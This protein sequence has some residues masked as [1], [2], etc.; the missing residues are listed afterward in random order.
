[1]AIVG[2]AS[3]L[4]IISIHASVVMYING[5]DASQFSHIAGQKT[6]MLYLRWKRV[7]Q[8]HDIVGR[9]L[10][11]VM[12]GKQTESVKADATDEKYQII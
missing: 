7:R 12:N 5:I 9:Y 10:A 6:C 3:A 4:D 8:K 11:K 2:S 1:M